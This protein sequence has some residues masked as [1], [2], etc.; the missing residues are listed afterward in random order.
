M[1]ER[2]VEK[3]QMGALPIFRMLHLAKYSLNSQHKACNKYISGIVT[4]TFEGCIKRKQPQGKFNE[5]YC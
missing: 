4:G 1:S 3:A 5:I 2:T